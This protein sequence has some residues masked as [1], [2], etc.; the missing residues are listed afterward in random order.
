[1]T[2]DVPLS[3][4]LIRLDS[5]LV[6]S[7]DYYQIHRSFSLDLERVRRPPLDAASAERSSVTC[8]DKA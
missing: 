1:M 6:F 2:D 5:C 4:I 3:P 7:S 8:G